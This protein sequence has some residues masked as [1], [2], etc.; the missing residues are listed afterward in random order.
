AVR[1]PTSKAQLLSEGWDAGSMAWNS[2]KWKQN[3][4]AEATGST[5]LKMRAK[6]KLLGFDWTMICALSQA[7][8]PIGVADV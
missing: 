2:E 7:S 5:A 6:Q 8:V 3:L 1:R 4:V